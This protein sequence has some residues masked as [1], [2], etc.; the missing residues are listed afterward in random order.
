MNRIRRY[1]FTGL[2]SFGLII[3]SQCYSPRQLDEYYCNTLAGEPTQTSVIIAARLHKSDTLVNN[4]LEGIDGYIKFRITRDF[5]SGEYMES[6][7]YKASVT[8]NYSAKYEF[9]GLRPGQKYFYSISYGK[10]TLNNTSSQWC[11]LNTL[12]LPVS[13]KNISFAVTNALEANFQTNRLES[14]TRNYKNISNHR[15]F[16]VFN[17][18]LR[19]NPDFWIINGLRDFSINS[20][21]LNKDTTSLSGLQWHNLF[22]IPELNRIL[23]FIPS[24]WILPGNLSPDN[25]DIDQIPVNTGTTKLPKYSRTY[26]LN[27]D[28]QIWMLSSLF[29]GIDEPRKK[30]QEMELNWLKTTLKESDSPF[31]L[32]VGVSAIVGSDDT[33]DHEMQTRSGLYQVQKDSL[34]TWLKNNGLRNNG[35][36]FICN[37]TDFQYHSMNQMG[38]EEFSSGS[39]VN[40]CIHSDNAVNDSISVSL[41]GKIIQP[42]VQTKSGNGFLMVYSRR[43]EYNSPVLVF[44]F[45][46]EEGKLLYSVSKY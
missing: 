15:N 16:H 9:T 31:K 25:N 35:L 27:R 1:F 34:F 39:L 45:F 3:F 10:D 17:S 33:R 42:Y 29:F 2:S 7:F 21:S 8:N 32:I 40:S 12:N 6:P 30:D 19:D 4:N 13:G 5:Q 28:V 20:E 14:D 36:Y 18:I 41:P 44:R 38:F 22:S 23:T 24:F 26:R 46:D 37:G 43:N 11:S